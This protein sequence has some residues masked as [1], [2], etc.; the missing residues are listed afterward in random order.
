[1]GWREKLSSVARLGKKK[2]G[3][4]GYSQS[5]FPTI[6]RTTVQP[7]DPLQKVAT[8]AETKAARSEQ[9]AAEEE[10]RAA[11]AEESFLK[12]LL[13]KNVGSDGI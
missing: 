5:Y 12:K 11:T 13:N 10:R 8:Q 1:M 7:V 6:Q 9:G 2:V 4:S 3:S